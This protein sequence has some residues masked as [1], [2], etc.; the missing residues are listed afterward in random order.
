M[1]I[2][3]TA[4]MEQIDSWATSKLGIPST[5]LMENA[6]R[7][8]VDVLET[9]HKLARLRVL[10]VC[11][12]GNN[13]GDGFVAARHLHNRGA[14]VNIS[15]LGKAKELKGD[16]LVNHR[17]AAN[18][19]MKIVE[20][21]RPEDLAAVRDSLH[22]D[23]MIDAIF[24]TGFSGEP[25]GIYRQA[26]ELINETEAFVL[27]IDIPSGINGDNGQFKNLC[28][29]ADATASMCLPKRGN[30]LFPGR[31][32]G[33]ELHHVD[34]GIPY[35]LIDMGS[36]RVVEYDDI[37]SWIPLR[38][39]DGN[40]GTF[41]Q[42]LVVAGARG[43]SGAAAMSA[44][45]ALRV[46]AGLV[47]L[48][49][50]RGIIDALEAKL[51]EVVKVPL[52][53]TESESIHADALETLKPYIPGS[54]VVVVGPGITTHPE[55]AK[56]LREFLSA[57]TSPCIIDADAINIIAQDNSI[58]RNAHTPFILT[59]HPGELARLIKTPPK[60][61]NE[62]RIETA[63]ECAKKYNCV[64][65]LKGA[66]TVIADQDGNTYVNPTGNSG[67]ATAGSGDVLVGM[68]AGF[69][70]QQPSLLKAAVTGVF[71]HGLC[72]DLALEDS[73]EF[74]LTAADLID[75]APQ[76]INFLLRREFA[77]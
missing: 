65:V 26:I 43:F 42:I 10:V 45:S 53:Q 12:K 60:D 23:V 35:S 8:C 51:L 38:P 52:E 34:I 41:G 18:T 22:P 74:A 64:M 40:K 55:T 77:R 46:G 20:I 67:L 14:I 3:T 50:P 37:L 17:L 44:Q 56:F 30:Y 54:D 32:F 68:I 39:A 31:E 70:A 73:N 33:G 62:G 27:S 1:R 13:G 47:R 25:Q 19:H 21:T 6:G 48:G 28:V 15:L 66:P 4:E 36:P 16:A 57:I 49:A 9:Y 61:I 71:L 58:L 76:A 5:V 29:I 2:V 7:G 11:G 75:Y 24:G 69:L 63:I 59:P 72:A